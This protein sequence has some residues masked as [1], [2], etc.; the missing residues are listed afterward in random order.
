MEGGK[1][2][3]NPLPPYAAKLSH[4]DCFE[5]NVETIGMSQIPYA[6]VVGLLMYAM[7]AK[8]LDLAHVVGVVSRYMSNP[9][10]QDW[11]T[12]RCILRYLIGTLELSLCYGE[13][14]MSLSGYAHSDYAWSIDSRKSTS[15]YVFTIVG[16]PISWASR[17]QPCVALSTIEAEYMAAKEALW[18]S[19]LGGDLGMAGD[20]PMLHCASQSAIALARNYIFHAKTNHFIEITSISGNSSKSREKVWGLAKRSSKDKKKSRLK[21]KKRSNDS[22]S[23]TD[24]DLETDTDSNLETNSDV[25]LSEVAL[26]EFSQGFGIWNLSN[27]MEIGIWT[28]ELEVQKEESWGNGIEKNGQGVLISGGNHFKATIALSA[29][30]RQQEDPV[31]V[32][33]DEAKFESY[34]GSGETTVAAFDPNKE[35]TQVWLK[36]I[37]LYEFACLPWDAWAENEF[38]KQQ[39][40][41]IKEGEGVIIGDVRLTPKLVSKV[42]PAASGLKTTSADMLMEEGTASERK[43][44]KLLLGSPTIDTKSPFKVSWKDLEEPESK[45]NVFTMGLE[46]KKLE[47]KGKKITLFSKGIVGA[48]G[49]SVP[50]SL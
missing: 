26:G 34:Q 8:R 32:E 48:T 37:G 28:M 6:L 18:L 39:W 12:V 20:A 19:R 4:G 23:D 17:L 21:R 49:K 47:S 15:G 40:N 31:E 22:D 3:S 29:K 46:S 10:K 33:S 5:T 25:E 45:L 11:D 14:D 1:A 50:K 44:R 38:G 43:R 24:T 16:G 7:V 36:R 41:M 30:V 42:T 2:I 9:S 35:E 13:Q 27:G